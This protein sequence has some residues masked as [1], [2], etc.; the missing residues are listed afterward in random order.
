MIE[1]F[2]PSRSA[3]PIGFGGSRGT[4]VPALEGIA[5]ESGVEKPAFA[6]PGNP[7]P[8]YPAI[9]RNSGVEGG[10]VVQVAVDTLG[11]AEMETFKLL[12]SDHQMFT[13]AVLKVLPRFR[14]IPA[15]TGGRKVRM[16]V[17][18]PFEFVRR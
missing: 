13:D 5:F 15:E 18:I 3:G 6:L 1:Q 4:G 8:S 12:S 14:F 11:R 7:S 9:L 16:W 10:V 2:G 17:I